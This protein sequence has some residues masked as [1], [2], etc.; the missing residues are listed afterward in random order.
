MHEP[1]R[2]HAH[3]YSVRIDD[4]AVT[5]SKR[6]IPDGDRRWLQEA[7]NAHSLRQLQREGIL[8]RM[9][10]AKTSAG[11]DKKQFH[12][13]F[14]VAA[15]VFPFLKHS[16]PCLAYLKMVLT[17]CRAGN[18]VSTRTGTGAHKVP[19]PKMVQQMKGFRPEA[20]QGRFRSL[21]L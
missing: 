4:L 6:H 3:I 12:I 15:V 5:E 17:S 13:C 1:G 8:N 18:Q 19:E 14:P 11:T 2:A 9:G 16:L 20:P 7:T 21:V 10:G